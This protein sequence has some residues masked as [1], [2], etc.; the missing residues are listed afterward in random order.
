MTTRSSAAS[1]GT[2][3]LGMLA[4]LFIGLKLTDHIDWS[5]WWVLSPIWIPFAVVIFA[6]LC[7]FLVSALVNARNW[8]R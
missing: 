6:L 7:G 1:S 3:F 5:W 2:P 8:R 4:V